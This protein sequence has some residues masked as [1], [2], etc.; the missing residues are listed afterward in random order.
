[1]PEPRSQFTPDLSRRGFLSA[2]GVALGAAGLSGPRL[3]PAPEPP[4][5]P[6]RGA[7]RP[8]PFELEETTIAELSKGQAEGRWTATDL[9]Q[10][11]SERIRELDR[12][13]LTL[14]HVLEVNPD[15][16][17]IAADLDAERKAGK[18]RG[19]LH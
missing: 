18:I 15:A 5:R 14:R 6:G 16:A 7:L 17:R 10:L 2:A 19:P 11:Y 4:A 3:R 8:G 13:G 1:M 12:T 9:V